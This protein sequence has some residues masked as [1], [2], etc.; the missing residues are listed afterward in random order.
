LVLLS[1]CQVAQQAQREKLEA[2]VKAK[3]AQA[4]LACHS[5]P[6]RTSVA[7]AQCRNDAEAQ[8][9]PFFPYPDLL[10]ERL[11]ARLALADKVDRKQLSESEAQR[12]FGRMM[13]RILSEDQRRTASDFSSSVQD[14]GVAR[15]SATR[16]AL[17][18]G[19]NWAAGQQGPALLKLSGQSLLPSRAEANRNGPRVTFGGIVLKV[20]VKPGEIGLGVSPALKVGITVDLIARLPKK[21]SMNKLT[22]CATYLGRFAFGG[23]GET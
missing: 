3:I 20:W 9:R 19:Y 6:F 22:L 8:A 7:R 15:S 14:G 10:D 11:A 4:V 16:R 21:P 17:G 23:A 2:E 12:A 1:G 13:E 5:Q 18:A